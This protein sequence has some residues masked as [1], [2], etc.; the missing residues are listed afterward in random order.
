MP[1]V[2]ITTYKAGE[3]KP[4]VT[5]SIPSK[6]FKIAKK[7]LPDSL[8]KDLEKEGIDLSGIDE[9]IG[10]GESLGVILEIEDHRKN[11]KTVISI[12]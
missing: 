12:E 1:S 8:Y 11:E 2:K 4:E 5:I 3:V 6:V 7:L 9:L 10:S